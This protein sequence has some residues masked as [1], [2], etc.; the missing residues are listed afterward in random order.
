MAP[1]QSI[2]GS[3]LATSKL[4]QVAIILK[5]LF[6]SALRKKNVGKNT[7]QSMLLK[8]G[9]VAIDSGEKIFN[10]R[11]TTARQT[12]QNPARVSPLPFYSA[13]EIK[14]ALHC[15]CYYTRQKLF[16]IMCSCNYRVFVQRA[17]VFILSHKDWHI[18]SPI[19][20]CNN[21]DMFKLPDWLMPIWITSK[22]Q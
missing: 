4:F 2:L 10:S 22:V 15:G 20:Q 19:N 18:G 5:N 9:V 11:R 21:L 7:Y 1:D 8:T 3:D 17:K 6:G 13:N 12:S 14:E 16:L